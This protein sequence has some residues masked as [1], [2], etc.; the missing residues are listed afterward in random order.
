MKPKGLMQEI[1]AESYGYFG[2]KESMHWLPIDA[3]GEY[4]LFPEFFVDELCDIPK[5]I[6]HIVLM[7]AN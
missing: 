2:D 5:Q 3:L 4:K 6:E 7:E 1:V